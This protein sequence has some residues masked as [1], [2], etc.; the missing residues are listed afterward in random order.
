MPNGTPVVIRVCDHR[1]EC[2]DVLHNLRIIGNV[3]EIDTHEIDELIG[4]L[5]DAEFQL[6]MGTDGE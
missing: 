5:D 6:G 2:I 4:A 3:I 1:G